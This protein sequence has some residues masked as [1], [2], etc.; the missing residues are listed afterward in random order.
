[1]TPGAGM[2]AALAAIAIVAVLAGAA[3][4]AETRSI[5]TPDGAALRYREVGRG[6]PLLLVHGGLQDYR[7]WDEIAPVL[8]QRY[9]VIAY[10]RRN[11]WPGPVTPDGPPDGAADLHAED[12]A[13]LVRALKLGRVHVVAH[14]A[15]AHAALFFAAG[16]P[17][18]V[19]SLIVNE[20]P[21]AGLL[22]DAAGRQAASGFQAQLQPAQ[23]AFRSGDIE[24]GLR[25]FADA[26]GGPGGYARRSS[27]QL[28]MMRDNAGAHVADA[29][30]TRPRPVFTCETASNITAP[31]LI[32]RGERSPAYFH[33]VADALAKC[34]PD[35]RQVTL[36]AY[37]NVPGENPAAF[38]TA[39]LEFT[40]TR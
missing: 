3:P 1:M 2:K 32:T 16:H 40:A 7:L 11:H 19:Q 5:P 15:G 35:A 27:T 10:S 25:L 20:P 4:A 31:V 36:S 30:T 39:V 34:L 22:S 29:T 28:Q 9:R 23:A 33:A 26:V 6:A 13:F 21:A 18:M 14:S 12:M 38:A 37:H 17:D 8:G 24:L